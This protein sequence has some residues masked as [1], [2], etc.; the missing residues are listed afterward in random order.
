MYNVGDVVIY[1]SHGLCSIED[2]C[3]QTFNSIT[4][5]YYVLQ[6]L[7]EPQLVIRTPID[8]SKKQL[9]DIIKKEEALNILH[10]FT[11]PGVE[12][13]EQNTHR[14]R[15]HLEIFKS[16]NRQKQAKLLNTLLR[17]KIE[18]NADEKKFPNQEE[19]LLQ[20]LQENIFSEFS[21]ALNKSS[22][23]IYEYVLTQLH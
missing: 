7:N 17:K 19:K 13:I 18:Y 10:S 2:I 3:E 23:E 9:R 22:D 5:T 4:K 1:S 20:S 15:V 8:N 11:S 14:S 16:G 6:P 21:I 12:W